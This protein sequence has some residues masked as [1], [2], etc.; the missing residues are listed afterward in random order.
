MMRRGFPTRDRESSFIVESITAFV[1]GSVMIIHRT[2]CKDAVRRVFAFFWKLTE[3]F[4]P[5]RAR[6][7]ENID[8][9][10]HR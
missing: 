5:Q 9:R 7:E 6:R 10:L 2:L 1:A 8:H 3:D 4:S